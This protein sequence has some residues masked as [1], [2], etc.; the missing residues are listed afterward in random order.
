MMK[1]YSVNATSGA[2]RSGASSLKRLVC[3]ASGS[4]GGRDVTLEQAAVHATPYSSSSVNALAAVV[5][6]TELR[7][8]HIK[9][10]GAW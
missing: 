1:S 4:E 8:L 3:A 6:L 9:E 5:T 2:K 7:T 10:R